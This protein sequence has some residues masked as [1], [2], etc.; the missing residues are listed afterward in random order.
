MLLKVS[1]RLRIDPSY[2]FSNRKILLIQRI[3]PG[4]VKILSVFKAFASTSHKSKPPP[5]PRAE[6][7]Y[8]LIKPVHLLVN[9]TQMT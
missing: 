3:K 9:I 1:L 8:R 7:K 4:E 5:S 6:V 2:S